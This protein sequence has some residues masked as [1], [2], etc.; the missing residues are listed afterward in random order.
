[1]NLTRRR[2][3]ALLLGAASAGFAEDTPPPAGRT[4]DFRIGEGFEA[5][6]SNIRAVLVS[7]GET[8]WQHCPNTE[9]CEP[10]FFIFHSTDVPITA[11]RHR[12]DGRVAIGLTS[13]G[14]H[15]AQ[16][17]YQFAHEFCHALA[18]HS[19]DF[20]L[21]WTRGRKAN[22]WFEESLAE[23][24]S[25]FAL[26]AMGERWK[27]EPPYRNWKPYAD[28][29]ASYAADRSRVA[30]VDLADQPFPEWF[31]ENEAA[32]RANAIIR[33]KNNIVAEQLLPLFEAEPTGWEAITSL[34]LGRR[35]PEETLAT[36]FAEWSAAAPEGQQAF[37]E[38]ITAVF[39][40]E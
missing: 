8:V 30:I 36:R 33:E 20:T 12:V 26:R 27:V 34:N 17:A 29:L 22:L 3:T 6:E 18:G 24:S 28:S 9:W 7:A 31:A 35:D 5:P 40:L 11:Y 21:P 25:L 10:G 39:G 19:N 23:T 15:W 1:M 16:L 2:F 38:K 37:I 13:T 32:M 14:A 4:L